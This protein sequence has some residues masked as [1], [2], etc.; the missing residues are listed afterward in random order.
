MLKRTSVKYVSIREGV[1]SVLRQSFW[2]CASLKQLVSWLLRKSVTCYS[3]PSALA[4]KGCSSYIRWCWKRKL[5]VGKAA[6][7][8]R[9]TVYQDPTRVPN[10]SWRHII[11]TNTLRINLEGK[12]VPVHVMKTYAGMLVAF[13][14]TPSAMNAATSFLPLAALLPT[15]TSHGTYEIRGSIHPSV[16]LEGLPCRES[17]SSSSAIQPISCSFYRLSYPGSPSDITTETQ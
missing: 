17:N 12:V 6:T 10:G 15:E 8:R 16:S 7:I 4:S 9:V 13:L 5:C 2:N 1:T 14:F 3:S 11:Y